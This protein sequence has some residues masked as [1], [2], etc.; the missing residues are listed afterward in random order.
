MFYGRHYTNPISYP[1]KYSRKT[2]S[3][4]E[5]NNLNKELV[6]QKES[7]LAELKATK[8]TYMQ[9]RSSDKRYKEK[10]YDR[11]TELFEMIGTTNTLGHELL[12]KEF[13]ELCEFLKAEDNEKLI[14]LLIKAYELQRGVVST[15]SSSNLDQ[16]IT[17]V[18]RDALLIHLGSNV[19]G[20]VLEYNTD[21][22]VSS[23]L[24]RSI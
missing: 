20:V 6:K 19:A 17:S 5:K 10:Q 23:Q 3:S 7:M 22:A 12:A 18:C 1:V 24:T 11:L 15:F 16:Y 9:N 4:L 8:K 2:D 13:G 21:T 14:Q